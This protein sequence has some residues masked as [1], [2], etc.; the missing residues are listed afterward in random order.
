MNSLRDLVGSFSDSDFYK[1]NYDNIKFEL[2]HLELHCIDNYLF[3]LYNKGVKNLS[4]KNN[5]NL[6]YL[7]GITN[8]PPKSRITTVGGGFP[9]IDT[10]VE[11][12]RREEVFDYLKD[13]YGD[14]FAH[15]GTVTYTAGKNVWKSAARIH[16]LSF[17]MSNK[18]SSMM[19]DLNC[20]RLEVL[21]EENKD[22]SD[23]YNKDSEFREVWDDAIKLQDCISS[24]GVHACFPKGM[25]V[26][27][28]RNSNSA[29]EYIDI[30]EIK[31]GYLVLTHKNRWKEVVDTQFRGVD[32]AT[33]IN[34]PLSD[35]FENDI[36]RSFY[37]I[38][39]TDN[40]PVLSTSKDYNDLF[41]IPAGYIERSNVLISIDESGKYLSRRALGAITR[42]AHSD[43]K[44][45]VYNIT[46]LDDSSYICNGIVVHNCGT[47]LSDNPIYKDIPLWES[48]GTVV[49]QYEA[50][51]VES[52]GYVKLDL[53]GSNRAP[54]LVTMR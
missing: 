29:P 1:N 35:Q 22:I 48:K 43:D 19:P 13:K 3:N 49:T 7:I 15:I 6:A 30:S 23:L 18:I 42:R 28:K 46:V 25:K 8:E 32:S 16:G 9:D 45:T 10:D 21:L 27:S 17:A 53:L 38:T 5:S 37:N 41:W 11:Q 44:V 24:T 12:S 20:P 47:I 36:H 54:V 34:I 2:D 40:H 39:C 4:N 50:K 31:I 33:L 51:E 52:L 14:G 26:Y